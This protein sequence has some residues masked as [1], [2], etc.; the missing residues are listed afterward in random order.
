MWRNTPSPADL[1]DAFP[2]VAMHLDTDLVKFQLQKLGIQNLRRIRKRS[3]SFDLPMHPHHLMRITPVDIGAEGYSEW[4]T[5]YWQSS[6][7]DESRE[8]TYSIRAH[9]EIIDLESD[10]PKS[11]VSFTLHND[12]VESLIKNAIVGMRHTNGVRLK[13]V[14][15]R[16]R[17]A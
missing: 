12:D 7:D 1:R 3:V 8:L 17:A 2:D 13:P 10:D 14:I 16:K 15:I 9:V 4:M 11:S 5:W 6:E